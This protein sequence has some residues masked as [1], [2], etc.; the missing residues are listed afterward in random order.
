VGIFELRFFAKSVDRTGV[1][2]AERTE[3]TRG[4]DSRNGANLSR[5][6]VGGNTGIDI[7]VPTPSP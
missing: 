1:L 5:S 7:D 3:A 6:L 2:D 4:M